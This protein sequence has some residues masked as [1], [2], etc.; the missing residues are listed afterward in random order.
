MYDFFLS[1]YI[2][3]GEKIYTQKGDY[4]MSKKWLLKFFSSLLAVLLIT[5]CNA[6]NDDQNPAPPAGNQNDNNGNVND[7][8]PAD[9]LNRNNGD[10][11]GNNNN[12]NTLDPRDDINGDDQMAPGNDTNEGLGDDER[13]AVPDREDPVE[14]QRDRND[15]NR[16][17]Q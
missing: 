16:G 12:R 1:G 3:Q 4:V 14:D 6:G 7:L 5:G 17:D 15:R 11:G 2:K 13:D 10:N 9:G 8:D